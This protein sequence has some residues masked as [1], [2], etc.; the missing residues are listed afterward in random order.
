MNNI[1]RKRV[2]RTLLLVSAIIAR[3]V[4]YVVKIFFELTMLYVVFVLKTTYYKLRL[5]YTLWINHTPPR[6]R[7]ELLK[8]YTH[9]VAV[10][11][12][13][14]NPVRLVRVLLKSSPYWQRV[15]YIVSLDHPQ[16]HVPNTP[17]IFSHNHL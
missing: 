10:I 16:D 15:S 8:M 3:L 5:R 1:K 11:R 13:S 9:R 17:D 7:R 4:F 12:G 14:I 6:L 2:I